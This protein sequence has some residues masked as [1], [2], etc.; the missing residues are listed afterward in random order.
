MSILRVPIAFQSLLVSVKLDQEQIEATLERTDKLLT[1]G[2]VSDLS[3]FEP[4]K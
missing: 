4:P 3:A 2:N 1:S